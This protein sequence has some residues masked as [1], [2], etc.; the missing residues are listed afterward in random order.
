MAEQTLFCGGAI[1]LLYFQVRDL[2]R[3][4][5]MFH[6]AKSMTHTEYVYVL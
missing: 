1:V 4:A 2:L 5:T 3:S 6:A